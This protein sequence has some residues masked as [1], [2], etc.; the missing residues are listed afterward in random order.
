MLCPG[1]EI[2]KNQWPQ[3]LKRHGCGCQ[4]QACGRSRGE[5][6]TGAR[7]T[8][9]QARCC[10]CRAAAPPDA[11]AASAEL[12]ASADVAPAQ[13]DELLTLP[14][15]TRLCLRQGGASESSGCAAGVFFADADAACSPPQP[16]GLLS[17]LREGM[18]VS[19]EWCSAQGSHPN[20]QGG[21]IHFPRWPPPH[22]PAPEWAFVLPLAA[23]EEK[24]TFPQARD[25]ARPQ[26]LRQAA[27]GLAANG[28]LG[29][30]RGSP[31][32]GRKGG[33]VIRGG[34]KRGEG[35]LQREDARAGCPAAGLAE[36][37]GVCRRWAA[38]SR[39]ALSCQLGDIRMYVLRRFSPAVR[40]RGE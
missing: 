20:G 34:W 36:R 4:E 8:T 18:E 1:G 30:Q 40:K 38:H 22:R 10:W 17:R 37:E 32:A 7:A 15:G 16:R 12:G 11:V 33:E 39:A 26:Q 3:S 24:V 29:P 28:R 23:E 6:R 35:A 13:S 31:G 27:A 9:A 14:P 19:Y 2:F 25:G 21:V 5:R